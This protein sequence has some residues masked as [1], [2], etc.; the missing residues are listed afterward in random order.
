MAIMLLAVAALWTAGSAHSSATKL[1]P[2][3]RN[4]FLW[5]FAA[6]SIWNTPIG[7]QAQYSPAHIYNETLPPRD[8]GPPPGF[9]NDQ[10]WIV[11]AAATD[12]L[13]AWTNDA[14]QFPGGCQAKQSKGR[15]LAPP[16]HFPAALVTDC[17]GNNNAAA[18]LSPDNKTVL[19]TQPLYRPKAGG[20]LISWYQAGVRSSSHSASSCSAIRF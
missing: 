9:H 1:G 14:G 19:Q 18:I 10:D 4:P 20:A 2:P 8:R 11:R 5:P 6:D 16:I 7:S 13:T 17:T 3:C 15:P 12:P